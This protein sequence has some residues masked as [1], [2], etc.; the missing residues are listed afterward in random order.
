MKGNIIWIVVAIVA[1][2]LSFSFN[3]VA[4]EG[5]TDTEIHI[6]QWGPQTGPARPGGPSPAVPMRISR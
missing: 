2:S 6:G 1:I 4:E 5:V 3:A